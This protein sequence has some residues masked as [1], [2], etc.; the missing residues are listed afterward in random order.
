GCDIPR[1]VGTLGLAPRELDR[2]I[3]C[4]GGIAELGSTL[5]AMLGAVFIRQRYSRL[6]I[7]CNCDPLE[8]AAIPEE[9]HGMAIP[10]NSGLGPVERY[11][12]VAAVHTPYHHAIGEEI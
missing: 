12:R 4:D 6:V 2:I 5:A 11:A 10:G 3:A 8:P 9:R 1:A 7:D